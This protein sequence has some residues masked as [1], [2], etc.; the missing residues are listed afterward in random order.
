MLNSPSFHLCKIIEQENLSLVNFVHYYYAPWRLAL[1]KASLIHNVKYFEAGQMQDSLSRERIAM[2]PLDKID[3]TTE[4]FKRSWKGIWEAV[5]PI[6]RGIFSWM[7]SRLTGIVFNWLLLDVW[8]IICERNVLEFNL[9]GRLSIIWEV[10]QHFGV[11][12][13]LLHRESAAFLVFLKDKSRSGQLKAELFDGSGY[14][15]SFPKDHINK[16]FSSLK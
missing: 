10:S 14:R 15:K 11:S 1:Q 7:W 13:E 3:A 5:A 6:N 2:S 16:H 12:F 8:N 9:R 4:L